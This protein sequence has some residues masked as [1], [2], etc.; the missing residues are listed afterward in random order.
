M[1]HSAR[2]GGFP[3]ATLALLSAATV[4]CS[5][6]SANELRCGRAGRCAEAP[7]S[8]LNGELHEVGCCADTDLGSPWTKQPGCSVWGERDPGGSECQDGLNYDDAVAFCAGIGGRLCTAAELEADCNRGTG[9]QHDTELLWSSTC[10]AEPGALA[11][12][13]GCL[14]SAWF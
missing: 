13:V 3:F 9:C 14:Q 6:Q 5:A 10:A 2:R 4:R 12:V 7:R 1:G 11:E 8:A